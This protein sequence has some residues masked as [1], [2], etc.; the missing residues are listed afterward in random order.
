MGKKKNA[1]TMTNNT[2][3]FSTTETTGGMPTP[4]QNAHSYEAYEE[5]INMEVKSRNPEI[6]K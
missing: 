5:L 6:K 3:T 4:P 2:S 1:R